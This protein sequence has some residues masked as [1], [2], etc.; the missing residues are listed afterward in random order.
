[1]EGEKRERER[2]EER[3]RERIARAK[4]WGGQVGWILV[5]FISFNPCSNLK[6]YLTI[7]IYIL[8]IMKVRHDEVT[9]LFKVTQVSCQ[10]WAQPLVYLPTELLATVFS[11]LMLVRSILLVV[12]ESSFHTY[13][14]QC[15]FLNSRFCLSCSKILLNDE[16]YVIYIN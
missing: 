10:S 9:K 7:F 2:K 3:E 5:H 14:P 12:V 11:C 4:F 16:L 1:M 13:S 15:L 8:Y 6:R